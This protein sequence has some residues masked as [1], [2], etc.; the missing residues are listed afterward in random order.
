MRSQLT[1][2]HV[3]T[4]ESPR[5]AALPSLTRERARDQNVLSVKMNAKELP[6]VEFADYTFVFH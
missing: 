3:K 6:S 1:V 2:D 5:L 4:Q